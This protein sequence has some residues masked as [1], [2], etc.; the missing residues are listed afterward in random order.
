MARPLTLL[1]GV[2]LLALASAGCLVQ[3]SAGTFD[4]LWQPAGGTGTMVC[5]RIESAWRP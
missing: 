3:T 5:S 1:V 2:L 4:C